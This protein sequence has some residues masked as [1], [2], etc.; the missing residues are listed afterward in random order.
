MV[1][2]KK[3]HGVVVPMI[4]PFTA[5]GDIDTDSTE[6]IADHISASGACVFVLGTT[7]ES[8]S[9]NPSAKSKL[10]N[11]VVK[12]NSHQTLIY[13]GIMHNCQDTS[14]EMAKQFLELGVDV[15]VACVPSYYPLSDDDIL[16]YFEALAE[17]TGGPLMLYNIPVTTGVSISLEVIDRLSH[18][19]TIIG[20]KDSANDIERMKQ[21]VEMWKNR[22]DFTY[23]CGCTSL[24]TT[25]LT[26]GADGI[27]PGV[28]NIVPG[29]FRKLYDAVLSGDLEQANRY[30]AR[31]DSVAGILQNKRN[32]SESLSVLKAIMHVLGFCSPKMLPPLRELTADQIQELRETVNNMHLLEENHNL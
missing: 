32:L 10:V 26:I 2:Q 27:V 19:P 16:N 4:T 21:A 6:R 29:L 17:R 31:S 11:T 13:A 30:Q 14:A 24:S 12:N 25:A 20:L 1:R 28:G 9:I 5:N 8:V 7:G 3:Y 23:L 18:H 22:D 15:V